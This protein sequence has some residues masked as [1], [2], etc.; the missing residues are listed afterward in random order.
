VIKIDYQDGTG[1]G[2]V[3]WKFGKDGDFTLQNGDVS[4][5]QYAQHF[6][7]ILSESGGVMRLAIWDNGNG[8]A[9]PDDTACTTAC[10][11]RAVIYD[12][13]QTSKTATLEWKEDPNLFAPWGGSIA[14]LENGNVEFDLPAPTGLSGSR[15]MEVTQ[16]S[17]PQTI[18][19]MDLSVATAYRA[20]RV[21][22]LY[23]GVQW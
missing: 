9:Q 6:P 20:Y 22:S 14:E 15:V 10:F 12:L 23:P 16:T 19:Q 13:D 8:R 2:S 3:A 21:P 1:T 11:S 4:D 18:W 5:W 17:M 7:N